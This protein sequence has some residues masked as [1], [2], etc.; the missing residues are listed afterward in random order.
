[1]PRPSTRAIAGHFFLLLLHDLLSCNASGGAT[2]RCC[3]IRI[4]LYD[5]ALRPL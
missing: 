5:L 1:M 4:D 2:L 3:V